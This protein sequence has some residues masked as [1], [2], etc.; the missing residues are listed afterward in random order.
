MTEY[1]TLG[2]T[3]RDVER[4]FTDPPC[5]DELIRRG[6]EADLLG[7]LAYRLDAA[8][9]MPDVPTAPR[10]HLE[11]AAVLGVAQH[12]A[13]ARE[14]REIL[15]AIDGL[16][17]PV[18]L[19]KG[20]AYLIANLPPARGR[21]F[22]DVDILVPKTL[23]PAV[24]SRLMLAGYAT[25]HHHP[26]DQR[27]YRRWMHELP[28]MQHIKRLTV[29]DVHHAIVPETARTHPDTPEFF[30][31]AIP[32]SEWP[33][34]A[35]LAPA[36]MVLHSATHLF[37]NEEFTHGLRDLVDIDQLLRHFGSEAAFWP[38]LTARAERMGLAGMLYYAFRFTTRL[39]ATPVPP[40]AMEAIARHGPPAIVRAAMDR[41]LFAGL[42]PTA[43]MASTRFARR[44]LN[45]RGH[46]LKMPVP[47]LA[48]HLTVKSLRREQQQPA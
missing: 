1:G 44:L 15:R 37:H 46:W 39:L 48:W 22:S 25:T 24:E 43:G 31:A 17:V 6:R 34:V 16:G 9:R 41:L 11:S 27:Y 29:I 10:R 35:V 8:G 40:T 21:L 20:A 14:V 36:D 26:H 45:L 19:L 18:I 2:D 33:G 38:A 5:W 3:L 12:R 7:T 30:R 32:V 4:A 13:V 47:L 23:L 28:P 42:R